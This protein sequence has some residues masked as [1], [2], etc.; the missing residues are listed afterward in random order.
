MRP[1]RGQTRPLPIEAD[2]VAEPEVQHVDAKLNASIHN[3]FDIEVIDTASGKVRQRAQAENVICNQLWTYMFSGNNASMNWNRYI[4]YGSGSGTPSA[5]D[6]ALFRYAGYGTPVTGDDVYNYESVNAVYSIKRKITLSE[7]TAVGVTITEIGI[8]YS[9]SGN[10]CTHAMLVD[11]NGNPISIAKTNT[12]IIN[13]YSTVFCHFSGAYRNY[14]A[15]GKF[16]EILKYAVG[17]QPY[18]QQEFVFPVFWGSSGSSNSISSPTNTYNA[19]EKTLKCTLQRVAAASGNIGGY[20]GLR[21]NNDVGLLY[22]DNSW[23]AG[24][25]IAAEAIGTGD[26]VAKDFKT[27]FGFVRAGAKVYANG[28]ETP[29]TIDTSI[30]TDV[31]NL[32]YCLR[33]VDPYGNLARGSLNYTSADENNT[34][35]YFNPNYSLYGLTKF[36]TSDSGYT[37]KLEASNDLKTWTT[38]SSNFGS[39]GVTVPSNLKNNKYWRVSKN[40]GSYGLSLIITSSDLTGYNIHFGT[41]PASGS[42]ITGDYETALIAK[43]TNHVFDFSFTIQFG[44]HST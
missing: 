26:G 4:Q 7:T 16:S 36:A 28:V 19:S 29:A 38:I 22:V 23:Y 43:D 18:G 40:T 2:I 32:V 8:G 33:K 12:D 37:G 1:I 30:P 41:A 24:S 15:F 39:S 5:T 34:A 31:A 42:V 3:R 44:E 10:L 9:D 27:I 6:T 35:I 17:M 13:I 21:D 11:M 20:L 25:S 14:F